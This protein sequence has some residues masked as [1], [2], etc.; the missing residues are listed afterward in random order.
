MKQFQ[1]LR[2]ELN[3]NNPCET[4]IVGFKIGTYDLKKKNLRRWKTR[5]S[6]LTAGAKARI[7]QGLHYTPYIMKPT[8][9]NPHPTP[10]PNPTRYTLYAT[11]YTLHP[12]TI[13]TKRLRRL[14]PLHS[15]LTAVAKAC[16]CDSVVLAL[17]D[18]ITSDLFGG[19]WIRVWVVH[20]SSCGAVPFTV[21]RCTA[22]Q[23]GESQGEL[24]RNIH[25]MS[26]VAR[27]ATERCFS[28]G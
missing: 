22:P 9:H 15:I 18:W 5:R 24:H 27:S 21:L 17:Y 3:C 1:G 7:Y 2:Q 10:T 28:E 23:F 14:D 6:I 4:Q 26:L 20:V 13:L 12:C 19:L 16:T 11:P 25:R 8:A